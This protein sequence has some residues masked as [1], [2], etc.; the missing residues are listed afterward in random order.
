[1]TAAYR[2]STQ[3]SGILEGLRILLLEDEFLIAMDVEMLCRDNGAV[4]VTVV[5]SLDETGE[6]IEFDAAI[7]DL[8]LGGAST[9]D[10]ADSLKASGK[11]FVFASGHTDNPEIA[12]RF[13]GVTLVGKPYSGNDLIEAVAGAC[14][15]LSATATAAEE[16]GSRLPSGCA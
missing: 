5:R 12:T 2:R 10:F 9:L 1:M 4:D 15:R 11:P 14:G 8:F 3:L 16:I 6:K 13:P 7:V